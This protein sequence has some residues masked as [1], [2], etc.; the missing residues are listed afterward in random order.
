MPLGVGGP[1]GGGATTT[2]GTGVAVATGNEPVIAWVPV[3]GV[4]GASVGVI[5]GVLV[6][7]ATPDVER[8]T[9]TRGVASGV[10][11]MTVVPTTT[12]VDDSTPGVRETAALM[13]RVGAIVGPVATRVAVGD[14]VGDAGIPLSGVTATVPRGT[15]FGGALVAARSA[16]RVAFW[17]VS[18]VI[19]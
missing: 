1:T 5:V 11:V 10:F 12:I 9:S 8:M 19:W 17:D 15:I 3:I 6:A 4:E 16:S 2:G 13:G 18:T 7:S 14:S